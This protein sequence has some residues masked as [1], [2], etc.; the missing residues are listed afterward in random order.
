MPLTLFKI[1]EE[2]RKYKE[3]INYFI[4]PTI[5]PAFTFMRYLEEET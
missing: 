4:T 1:T 5:G 2:S 3:V